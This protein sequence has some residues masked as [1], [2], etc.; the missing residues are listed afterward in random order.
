MLSRGPVP[1]A[2]VVRYLRPPAL[3]RWAVA[4]T[5][6]PP[7]TMRTDAA[8]ASPV[9]SGDAASAVPFVAPLDALRPPPGVA[10]QGRRLQRGVPWV[11]IVAMGAVVLWWIVS[12][13]G[14]LNLF[15][16]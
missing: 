4:R 1:A 10:P 5:T 16:R 7:S 2:R 9:G 12:Q 8:T 3:H 13:T 6:T 15:F 11:S 14:V